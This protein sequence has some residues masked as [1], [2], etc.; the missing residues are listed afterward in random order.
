[1]SFEAEDVDDHED[2]VDDVWGADPEELDPTSDIEKK[3]S[4]DSHVFQAVDDRPEI[5]DLEERVV[6]QEVLF[7]AMAESAIAATDFLDCLIN[8]VNLCVDGVLRNTFER[9][10]GGF[11]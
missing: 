11:F 3:Q 7:I 4:E 5:A 8:R 9:Q 10:F 6:S 2:T 1:M